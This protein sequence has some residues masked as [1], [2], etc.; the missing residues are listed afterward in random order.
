MEQ[1]TFPG[2]RE[3]SARWR[4]NIFLQLDRWQN[5]DRLQQIR[6]KSIVIYINV[7]A[8]RLTC[9]LQTCNNDPSK[10]ERLLS[11]VIIYIKSYSVSQSMGSCPCNLSG[12]TTLILSLEILAVIFKCQEIGKGMFISKPLIVGVPAQ[13]VQMTRLIF[14]AWHI[15]KSCTC[16]KPLKI[17]KKLIF[18]TFWRGAFAPLAPPWIHHW[19]MLRVK[20][21]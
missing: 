12:R 10:W 6:I 13:L 16:P 15:Q 4:Q 8:I 1:N 7:S 2:I 21:M 11:S 20:I 5:W 9:M 17:A 19:W 14:V 3:K 18:W